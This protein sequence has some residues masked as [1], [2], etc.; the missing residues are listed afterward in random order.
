MFNDAQNL[1]TYKMTKN[2]REP[3]AFDITDLVVDEFRYK[4]AMPDIFDIDI[5]VNLDTL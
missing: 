3:L 1:I 2:M 4:S 5:G